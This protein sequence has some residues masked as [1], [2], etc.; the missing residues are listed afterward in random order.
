M[1]IEFFRVNPC[2]NIS[3]GFSVSNPNEGGFTMC[4][5]TRQRTM[6][7]NG[8]TVCFTI[9]YRVLHVS[10]S[11]ITLEGGREVVKPPTLSI[12]VGDCVR[13]VGNVIIEKMS[14]R[15]GQKVRSLIK[16]IYET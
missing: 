3:Y 6:R 2:L 13:V 16:H 9:P 14:K 10:S 12:S 1:Y 7:Y 8:S 5:Y 4:D 15:E 11:R